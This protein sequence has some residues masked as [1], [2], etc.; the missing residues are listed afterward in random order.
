[1]TI[2]ELASDLRKAY[3]SAARGETV[4][5]IHLFGITHAQALDGV[6]LKELVALAGIP[7]SYHTEIHK[8]I[9]LAEFVTVK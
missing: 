1:M 7:E 3:N 8:G 9:R 5:S 2:A 6:S 4:V